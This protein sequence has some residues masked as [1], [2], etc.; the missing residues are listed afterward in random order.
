MLSLSTLLQGQGCVSTSI[1]PYEWPSHRN[2]FFAPNAWTG[3]VR[4]MST[5]TNT[6]VGVV[7]TFAVTSYEGVSA[8]SDD[9]GNLLFYTNG[10]KLWK[11]TGGST[12]LLSSA[13]TQGNEGS[14]ANGSASQGV[15]ITRH[16]LDPDNYYIF[17]TDDAIG[18]TVG[19]NYFKFSKTGVLLS[20]PTRLGSYRSTEGVAA[21]KHSNGV[22]IW[23]TVMQSGSTN[24]NT[25]LLTCTGLNTT[26]VVSSVAPNVSGNKE[27]GGIAFSYD[28]TKFAQAHPN[29]SPDGAKE[30]SLY[31]FNKSTGA[32]TNARHIS[33]TSTT[34]APYDVLF[35]PDGNRLYISEQSGAIKYYN[36]SSGVAS[37]IS[38]TYT[39]TGVSVGY[40]SMEIGPD[41][42]LY[43]TSGSSGGSL[44]KV[45]GDLNTGTSF[46]VA[47]VSGTSGQAS[48]GL[49]TMYLPPAEEPDIQEVGPY[50][51]GDPAVDL[52]TTW[53]CSGLNA[54]DATNY[55]TEYAGTGITNTGIG[56]FNP[57]TAGVGTHRI[58][59]TRCS[60]DDTIWITVNPKPDVTLADQNLCTGVSATF[61][62]GSGFSSY[63]WSGNGSGSSQT[64]SG[65]AD[66]TYTVIVSNS[67]G[68]KDTASATL[69]HYSC[70][71]DTSLSNIPAQCSNGGTINLDSYKV[72][73]ESG[74]WS[75][76][77]APGGST[78]TISGSTFNVN[79]TAGGSYVVR[80]TLSSPVGGCAS[81]AERTIV[82][83]SKPSVTLSNASICSGSAAAS[84]DAGS[85]YSS[86][87]W[88]GNGTGTSQTTSG[89]LAGTYT[90]IVTSSNGCKDTA[91]ATLTVNAK[92]NISLTNATICS[93]DAAAT[94]DAGAGYTTY[95]WSGNGTGSSRTTTGTTA[96]TY[97]VIV[98]DANGC[99][100]TAS[101]TLTVN[102]KPSVTLTN[103]TICSGDA[104]ASFDAGAGYTTYAW[105]GNGTGSSRTTTGT[106][107]G[108]YTVIVTDAN[109]CKDT[110]SATLTLNAKPNVS[111]TNAV[112][113]DGDAAA[114]FDAG[115]GYTTYAW[116]GNGTGSAQTTSGTTAGTYTVIVTDAN[117]CKDT[118]S[119]TLTVNAKPT[120]TPSSATICSG[121]AAVTFDAGAGYSSYA[122]SGPATGSSQ[123]I[124]ATIAGTYQVIVTAG[125][126]CKDTAVAVLT[127]NSKP[128]ATLTN[129]TICDGDAAA[130]FDAG[131]GYTTY[132]WSG[133]GTGAAQTTS[134]TT[135]GTYTL[136]VTDAN[137]CKDT[138]SATLTVNS[139]P[140]ISLANATICSGD[141]AATFDAGA[142]Y[143]TY[144][145]SGNGTGAAQTT[146]GTTAGTYTV[147]VTDAN[148][149]KDTSSATLTVYAKPSVTLTNA[150]IC[151]GDAAATF[152]AGAGYTTYAWS[153]NGTGSSQTTSGTAAGSYTVIVTDAN[154]CMDTA[155]ASLTINAKPN[156][157]LSNVTMCLGDPAAIFDAGAGYTTYAWSGNGTGSAQTTS[158]T[159]AGTYTVIVSDANA[160][161]DTASATLTVNTSLNIVINDETICDGETATFD[162]GPGFASYEWSGPA[163]GT[164]RTIS[165]TTAGTYTVI[166]ASVSGCRDTASANLTVNPLPTI[167][168][169]GDTNI[170]PG[171]TAIITATLTGTAPYTINASLGAS[172]FTF[173]TGVNAAVLPLS[174]PGTYSMEVTDANGCKTSKTLTIIMNTKPNVVLTDVTIC[175]G[176]AAAIFDAGAGYTS[177][178]WVDNGTGV[179]QTTSGTTAGNYT[180]Q[181]IDANGC[182]DTA[183]AV[184]TVNAKP[185][186]TLKNATICEGDAAATFDAGSGIHHMFGWTMEL[187]HQQQQA[188]QQ[189]ETILFK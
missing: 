60:V 117:G 136:I 76:T 99:K 31:D 94:F 19:F 11:G 123:T 64:T 104:A 111:L 73:S 71:P 50:C 96:G 106:T 16:P 75:I 87:A 13:I 153:D 89:T 171:E 132:A 124:S 115:A 53:L 25:Y 72:T 173:N 4:N 160:C 131:A 147:I 118:A 130:T 32:I 170:C 42:A 145:W 114:T 108:T 55:P 142:G 101:A 187:E 100:D 77:S 3:M 38:A 158:G 49:P 33:S 121:D 27:R 169:S 84:F 86:Y 62:A 46:S 36:I 24:F 144:A 168:L 159:T 82:I 186:F 188:E 138:A 78:A 14:L 141:A 149:C 47:N 81:Y 6:S 58:I 93:G 41:G 148:G 177:Y 185:N 52:S 189:Q 176:D 180:V 151:S 116:S 30:V 122:W 69:S 68:C 156:V 18:G 128:S 54:E 63:A 119:A 48:L 126:G 51:L 66:G 29:F 92:P 165:A 183:A 2:W 120:I 8:A 150:T 40:S 98:T 172:S 135:A 83:Y 146:S 112:I 164:S 175:E 90:V 174:L 103:V 39:S 127:V 20:G 43:T 167:S 91:S 61:D 162:A 35:S 152:D 137:G 7:G 134:R 57:T 125:S 182:K 21:T 1:Y 140:S 17:T 45:T 80:F 179:S 107:A 157:S 34:E 5:G 105:S 79:T 97:T 166:V 37:T 109:G 12:T 181:V 23:I 88:S 9:N 85:G 110:A 139:K 154:G 44:R 67:Y 10:R 178:V 56:I 184:L 143:T 129:V 26:P 28:G 102:A 113:C 155:Y 133:N 59:F 22:D 70:C 163:T 74:T 65:S 15:L 95:A 161:K